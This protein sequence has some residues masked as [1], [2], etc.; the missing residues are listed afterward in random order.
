MTYHLRDLA[1]TIPGITEHKGLSI[2]I[3]RSSDYMIYIL[4]DSWRDARLLANNLKIPEARYKYVSKPSDVKGA[5][6]RPYIVAPM[7]KHDVSISL[8]VAA[9]QMREIVYELPRD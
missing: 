4:A 3:V 8:A 6:G 9:E 7:F 5:T 2:P 1:L